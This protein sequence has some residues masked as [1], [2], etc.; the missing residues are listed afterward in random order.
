M[1]GETLIQ[2]PIRTVYK[3]GTVIISNVRN[4]HTNETTSYL[5]VDTWY[6]GSPMDDT[7]IDIFGVFTKFNETGEFLREILPNWGEKFLEVDSIQALRSLLPRLQKL[8]EVDYYKGVKV[9]GYWGKEDTIRP[10]NYIKASTPLPDDGGSIIEVGAYKYYHLFVGQVDVKYFGAK[11]DNITDN[12]TALQNAINI[13]LSV[14]VPKG[15]YRHSSKLTVCNDKNRY[16]IRFYGDTCLSSILLFSGESGVSVDFEGRGAGYFHSN[17]KVENIGFYGNRKASE[18]I[19]KKHI[20]L[21]ISGCHFYNFIGKTCYVDVCFQ[22]TF[23]NNQFR[24]NPDIVPECLLYLSTNAVTVNNRNYFNTGHVST[25]IKIATL[26]TNNNDCFSVNIVDNVFEGCLFAVANK[27]GENTSNLYI[28]ENYFELTNPN[29]TPVFIEEGLHENLSIVN[30]YCLISTKYSAVIK[31]VNQRS[32]I[33]IRANTLH[34]PVM[35][36]TTAALPSSKLP[37]NLPAIDV[38]YQEAKLVPAGFP[39]IGWTPPIIVNDGLY[40]QNLKVTRLKDSTDIRMP[41]ISGRLYKRSVSNTPERLLDIDVPTG[42]STSYATA[43]DCEFNVTWRLGPRSA[44]NLSSIHIEK[45]VMHGIF[46]NSGP[47]NHKWDSKVLSSATSP[48]SKAEIG[49]S[50]VEA[51]ASVIGTGQ[52]DNPQNE[53]LVDFKVTSF[54]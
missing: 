28:A 20:D 44:T 37:L 15:T 8:I 25:G 47:M 43:L 35:I 51:R 23:G 17:F 41:N 1:A 16:G 50:T 53:W 33:H 30:N 21:Q 39:D 7:K 22:V 3:D 36:Y 4:K 34:R 46:I 40:L 13:G 45:H 11:G 32:S 19:F 12:S 10:I 14:Y 48:I 38:D 27:K 29:N 24:N 9:N 18:I 49:I 5:V 54:N 6:D 26:S 2:E 31:N 42:G 52:L